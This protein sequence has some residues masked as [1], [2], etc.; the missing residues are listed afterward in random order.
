[1]DEKATVKQEKY[2]V[3]ADEADLTFIMQDTYINGEYK[4]TEDTVSPTSCTVPSAISSPDS[5]AR[6]PASSRA[7]RSALP[8]PLE[9]VL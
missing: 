6:R 3:F 5:S 2:T 7:L 1:M 9:K 4:S 8:L